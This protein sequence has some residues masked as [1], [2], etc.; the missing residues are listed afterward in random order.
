MIRNVAVHLDLEL[1]GATNLVFGIAAAQGAAIRAEN[2]EFST[3]A[4][5]VDELIDTHGSRLHVADA[6]PGRL[7]VDYRLEVEGRAEPAPTD[8]LDL[9]RYLRPSRYCE[10]D[11]LTPMARQTFSG[12]S[13]HALLTSVVDWVSSHL[14]Y[15]SG[16]SEPTDGAVQTLADRRGVCRDY[17]HLV[18]ALLRALDIPARMV[19]VYAP[20]LSPMDFHAVVEA[21][22]DG[23]WW[24]V[25]ATRLAPRQSMLRISTGRDA[26]DVAFLTNHG[27][28]L[29]LLTMEVLAV[30]DELPYDDGEQPVQLG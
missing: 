28:D 25:D 17:A 13:G 30:V 12:L 5:A 9:I 2:L 20:G 29:T 26:A 16:S 1:G 14:T 19:A 11:S 18:I 4:L 3:A 21:H 8:R 27:S 7:S 6:E 22:I 10:S 23:Q 24:L 15:V